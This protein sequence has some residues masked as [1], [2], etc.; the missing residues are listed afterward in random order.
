MKLV[1]ASIAS[2]LLVT[3]S[4]WNA[5][6]VM[7]R[8]DAYLADYEPKLSELIADEAM[9]Q[10]IPAAALRLLRNRVSTSAS[11]SR[12]RLASEVAFI[13]LPNGG[14]L[15]FRHVKTVN[16]V[17][18]HDSE[19]SL[20]GVLQKS[21]LEAARELLDSSA[22]HNLGLPRT[23]NLPNLPLEFL[24]AR[25]R[26]RLL[27]RLDGE[28]TVRGV[29]TSRIVLLERMTPSLIRNPNTGD[30]MP[31][32][33]RAWVDQRGRLMRAEVK[34]FPGPKAMEVAENTIVVEFAENKSLAM[35][36]PV[37][38]REK[39]PI[40]TEYRGSSVATYSNF[41]RFTTSGRIVQ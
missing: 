18:V 28:D 33:I 24:H 2:L 12:R 1:A 19:A 40:T 5:D 31:S 32:V 4:S 9:T 10:E 8:L 3:Q 34:T 16:N 38:M 23:T 15:G 41:R 7:A 29:R 26:K 6:P 27:P 20:G 39:F 37:Q 22:A 13:A 35:L 30:D 25:N 14:W 36:V 17:K 21:A 11:P